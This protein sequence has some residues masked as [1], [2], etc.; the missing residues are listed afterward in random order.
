MKLNHVIQELYASKINCSISSFWDRGYEVKLG[1]QMNGFKDSESVDT[2]EEAAIWLDAAARRHYPV[3]VYAKRRQ[4]CRIG[5]GKL[6][7]YRIIYG[8][9]PDDWTDSCLA[10]IPEMMT[11]AGWHEIVRV[12]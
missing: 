10:D 6:A 8:P 12:R 2:L 9:S 7:D 4:C 3:S 5:C 1:N 11:D